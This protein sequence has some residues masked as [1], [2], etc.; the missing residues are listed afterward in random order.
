MAWRIEESLTKGEVDNRV[1][2]RVTGRLWFMGRDEPVVLEL[3]GNAWRDVAGQ[4]LRFTNPQPK[5]ARPGEWDHFPAVQRGVVGD[6]TASRKVK[7]PDCSMDELMGYFEA[8]KPFPWHWGNSLYLE[9]HSE[10][11]GRV[12]IESASYT[13][14]LNPEAAWTMG[15]AEE[16][17]Q[18]EAEPEPLTSEQ[19]AERAEWIAEMNAAG[20]QAL[21]EAPW[22]PSFSVTVIRATKPRSAGW[23][24]PRRRR[25]RRACALG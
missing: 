2:G 16:Q 10:A 19:E 8:K 24:T 11:N 17:T 18:R 22:L 3:A 14:E 13:L 1:R 5:P 23:R 25:A 4:V 15:E 20:E 12:V 6:I 9:W 7:V 21:A